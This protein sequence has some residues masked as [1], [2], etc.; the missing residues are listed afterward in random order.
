MNN[1]V[2][3]AMAKALAK[4][5]PANHYSTGS[6]QV[7]GILINRE[8]PITAGWCGNDNCEHQNHKQRRAAQAAADTRA[9]R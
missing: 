7:K 9:K 8:P 1:P 6:P 3:E 4:K 5:K 2:Q